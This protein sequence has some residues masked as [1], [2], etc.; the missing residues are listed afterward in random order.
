MPAHPDSPPRYER[1]PDHVSTDIDQHTVIL[2]L[3]QGQYCELNSS[4]QLIWNTL[5][6]AQTIAEICGAVQGRFDVDASTCVKAVEQFVDTLL[7]QGL[8]RVC[9]A[10]EG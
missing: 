5:S 8:V 3:A 2:S 7:Q 10:T 6:Q 4:G 1:H 9:A